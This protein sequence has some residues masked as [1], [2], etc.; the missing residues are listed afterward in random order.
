MGV[1]MM[2]DREAQSCGDLE[3][4][5]RLAQM[6]PSRVECN[7]GASAAKGAAH[8]DGTKRSKCD[9]SSGESKISQIPVKFD[10]NKRVPTSERTTVMFRNIPHGYKQWN[11]VNLLDRKGFSGLYD[12]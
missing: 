5:G 2:A 12:F 10:Q 8:G 6:Q 3:G 7:R 1:E 9:R 11:L 4:D